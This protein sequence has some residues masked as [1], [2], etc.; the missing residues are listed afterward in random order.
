[1]IWYEAQNF[2][3][4]IWLFLYKKKQLLYNN[5]PLAK[6]VIF[7]SSGSYHQEQKANKYLQR[8]IY[9]VIQLKKISDKS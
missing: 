1:M 2:C 8:P 6:N 7:S 9:A 5:V 4:K 3:F